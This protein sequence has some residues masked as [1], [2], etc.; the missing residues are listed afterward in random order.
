MRSESALP[1]VNYATECVLAATYMGWHLIKIISAGA[2]IIVSSDMLQTTSLENS[3]LVVPRAPQVSARFKR[4]PRPS[5][6]RLLAD[7]E[8]S[9]IRR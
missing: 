4:N 1:L 8:A 5:K 9:S 7:M 3:I 2:S 6:L